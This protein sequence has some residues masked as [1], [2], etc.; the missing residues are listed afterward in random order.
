MLSIQK[1]QLD[2]D[3][4]SMDSSIHHLK[5]INE[6]FKNLALDKNNMTYFKIALDHFEA[7]IHETKEI[8]SPSECSEEL[9]KCNTFIKS[10][11][12]TNFK[13]S[14]LNT[15][16]FEET[17]L[18]IRLTDLLIKRA[19][20]DMDNHLIRA[21]IYFYS[22][23]EN[24]KKALEEFNLAV[25]KAN[26]I[27]IKE[28]QYLAYAERADFY[29]QTNDLG[30]AISDYKQAFSFEE[31]TSDKESYDEYKKIVEDFDQSSLSALQY[32]HDFLQENNIDIATLF[33]N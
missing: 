19:P 9:K 32:V 22:I 3:K 14:K 16:S 6:N 18:F 24:P 31:H 21:R 4:E 2:Q 11:N 13:I 28:N 1:P 8:P 20:R 30:N 12:N 10:Y 26:E 33:L 17:L 29:V 25:Q 7:L 23:L 5:I 15:M 27:G